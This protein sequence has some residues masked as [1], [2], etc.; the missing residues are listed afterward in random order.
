M[1]HRYHS[2]DGEQDD[3]CVILIVEHNCEDKTV[4]ISF[5]LSV[6]SNHS[7]FVFEIICCRLRINNYV[8]TDQQVKQ[9]VYHS[10]TNLVVIH[11]LVLDLVPDQIVQFEPP[12]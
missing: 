3:Q 2:I 10:E 6:K 7:Y 4:T 5:L 9:Q 12:T 11:V 8:G 1:E